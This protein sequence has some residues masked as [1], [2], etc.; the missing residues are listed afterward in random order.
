M[1]GRYSTRFGFEF[2]PFPPVGA[3]LARWNNQ[4]SPTNYSVLINEGGPSEC[5]LLC[6]AGESARVWY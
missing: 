3:T 2:T 5:G 6:R 4:M 1:T